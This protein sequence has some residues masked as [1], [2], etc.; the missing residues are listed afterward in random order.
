MVQFQTQPF[1]LSFTGV[2]VT[3]PASYG[4]INLALLELGRDSIYIFTRSLLKEQHSS[5][6]IAGETYKN[7]LQFY[8]FSFMN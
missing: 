2:G 6:V 7:N 5:K 8:Y 3:Q 4:L 1:C